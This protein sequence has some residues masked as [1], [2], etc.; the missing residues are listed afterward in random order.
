VDILILFILKQNEIIKLY[1][2][3]CGF[4]KVIIENYYLLLLINKMLD[5]LFKVIFF[6]KPDL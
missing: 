5:W 4:N 2:D 6:I 1:I 3:Y